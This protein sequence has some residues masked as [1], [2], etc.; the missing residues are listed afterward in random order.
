[1][2]SRLQILHQLD[3]SRG[4]LYGVNSGTSFS[5]PIVSG[6][7]ALYIVNHPGASPADVR[8]ALISLA[9]PWPIPADPD[10]FPE[11]IVNVSTL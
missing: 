4:G 1:L 7:A 11:G 8:A 5:A 9:E 2:T 6:A 10:S 3:L